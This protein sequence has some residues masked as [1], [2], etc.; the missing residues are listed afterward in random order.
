MALPKLLPDE[1]T[2]AAP[3]LDMPSLFVPG[4]DLYHDPA[5][6]TPELFSKPP[7]YTPPPADEPLESL[8][9]RHRLS[10]NSQTG[11]LEQ[12]PDPPAPPTGQGQ[13]STT[14]ED[15]ES[16]SDP[17]I[18]AL[19]G[20]T[21]SP[22]P[23]SGNVSLLSSKAREVYQDRKLLSDQETIADLRE[24]GVPIPLRSF[25]GHIGNDAKTAESKALA[26]EPEVQYFQTDASVVPREYV[27]KPFK[28]TD[29]VRD[30]LNF[31]FSDDMALAG[32]KWDEDGFKF[33]FDN[34]K[35]QLTE[36]PYVSALT[37]ASYAF[38]IGA[39]WMKG[40]R[41]A[42]RAEEIAK[43]GGQISTPHPMQVI[44]PAQVMFKPTIS[45]YGFKAEGRGFLGTK[46]GYRFDDHANLVKNLAYGKYNEGRQLFKESTVD[47]LRA[48]KTPEEVSKIVSP[49]ELRKMLISDHHEMAYLTLR[50]KAMRNQLSGPR[51]KASWWFQDKFRNT[52]YDTL[53]SMTPASAKNLHTFFKEAGFDKW[54][55][56][57]PIDL[58]PEH[59]QAIY[60]YWMGKGDA[61]ALA[62][63]IGDPA[64]TFVEGYR[65]KAKELFQSQFDEGMIEE[66]TYKLFMDKDK[67]GSEFHLPALKKLTPDADTLAMTSE[68]ASG[69][70]QGA[71]APRI[72]TEV[73]SDVARF[74]SPPTMKQRVK[75]TTADE[76]VQDI[77]SLITDP[78]SILRG[79]L[80]RDTLLTNVHRMFRDSI[81]GFVKKDEAALHQFISQA[82]LAAL[83]DS[84]SR[85]WV[86]FD[87]LN[88]VVPGLGDRMKRMVNVKLA[89]DG[90]KVTDSQMPGGVAKDFVEA[91]WGRHP[92]SAASSASLFGKFFELMST[93]HKTSMTALN[94][95]T[96]MNNI[97]GNYMFLAMAGYNPFSSQATHDA[98]MIT[99]LFIRSAQ[100]HRASIKS[101]AA[102]GGR[103]A[104]NRIERVVFDLGSV[105]KILDNMGVPRIMKDNHGGEIDLAEFFSS[106]AM[107]GLIEEQG[108]DSVEGLQH[109]EKLIDQIERI[110]RTE[111]G[112]GARAVKSAATA[113]AG[114][115]HVPVVE[116]VLKNASAA[117]LGEDMI[118]KMQYALHLRR[119]GWGDDAILREVGRRLPQYQTV[120]SL[121]KSFR[122][123]WFPWM[124]FSAEAARITKNNLMDHPMSMFTWM[125]APDIAQ[126]IVSGAGLGPNFQ[127]YED[128]LKTVPKWGDKWSTVLVNEGAAQGVV[129]GVGGALAGAVAGTVATG[130]PL[131]S[132]GGAVVGAAG[133]GAATAPTAGL[134]AGAAAGGMMG[135]GVPGMAIGGAVGL[136]A[137][138]ASQWLSPKEAQ[139]Q[140]IARENERVRA[141]MADFLPLTAL[142]PTTTSDYELA[143]LNP[144]DDVPSTG[145]EASRTAI[146]LS[147]VE[148]FAIVMP[149]VDIISGKDSFGKDIHARS[150]FEGV[151]KTSLNFLAFLAPPW[152]QKYGMKISG[153]DGNPIDLVE[154]YAKNGSLLSHPSELEL[155]PEGI[156]ARTLTALGGAAAG[157]ALTA[158]GGARYAQYA[159]GAAK[160]GS[161]LGNV[162][163]GA[164]AG[165]G[166]AGGL[167]GYSI[168]S[169]RLF[170]DLGIMND[171]DSQRPG[172]HT[173]DF[174][175]NNFFGSAK[176]FQ[177]SPNNVHRQNNERSRRFDEMRRV[178]E[179]NI[180]DSTRNTGDQAGVRASL[181]AVKNSFIAEFSN[182]EMA[183]RKFE[184]WVL[185]MVKGMPESSAFRGVTQEE[186]LLRL[187]AYREANNGKNQHQ[188][189]IARQLRTEL[190]IRE[191]EKARG[192]HINAGDLP[193]PF[194]SG[195]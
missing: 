153:P 33:G 119:K 94:P 195:D 138:L 186:L 143:K 60:K 97:V 173:L 89:K 188:R 165:A 184:E 175:L 61:T 15:A 113:I 125:R 6:E 18:D 59:E 128:A 190:Q 149:M 25:E 87:E 88:E 63:D 134:V 106:P 194:S 32:I 98:K 141:Y 90:L 55:A 182:S 155:T 127:E 64:M 41:V 172:E 7:K 38:P 146:N 34:V 176:S 52:Y 171:P 1:D 53:T 79:G 3:K 121:N 161:L 54:L 62:K 156:D 12:A 17:L 46:L 92:N 107:R 174:W 100:Q 133:L 189:Q 115:G 169:R 26:E 30:T 68:Y 82:D 101:A 139:D 91:L 112:H 122:K 22:D 39:A 135:G 120:G 81:A 84:A 19:L 86:K 74:L 5:T 110:G 69:L 183:D 27:H 109:A 179:N 49:Q 16:H 56:A 170:T 114:V 28:A 76:V 2:E 164:A 158:L 77:D 66:D 29:A 180:Y 157:L 144:G 136:G 191:A 31:V 80:I 85:H 11:T 40:A 181:A 57:A 45:K 159:K 10:W 13:P 35:Q 150:G 14:P 96:H 103:E 124:T 51:E 4:Q 104:V 95:A 50:K 72:T 132:L 187:T 8:L 123:L 42:K 44:D 193:L 168:N 48:A 21:E 105:S 78:Q 151:A 137:G 65:T 192:L 185:N 47:A 43:L 108:F 162:P 178:Y 23:Q 160:A 147:P 83:P 71:R 129:G 9:S 111:A 152:M 167:G 67:V 145:I 166:V 163:W 70:A 20:P 73:Q 154:S 117:Y 24:Q 142:T 118:P 102:G 99:R 116:N 130:S 131:G 37:I 93:V 140:N 177:G 148:P 126:G 75:Y 36:H 58:K